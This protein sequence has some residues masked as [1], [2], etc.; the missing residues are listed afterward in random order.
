MKTVTRRELLRYMAFGAAGALLAGCAQPTAT[1]KPEPTAVLEAT[2]A[3]VAEPTAVPPTAAPAKAVKITLVEAWFGV[4]QYRESI[5]PVNAEISKKMQSEGLNVEIQSMIL[6]NHVDKYPVLY[7]SGADFTMAFDA[8]WYKMTSLRDQGALLAI[9]D[10]VRQFGPNIT[11]KVTPEIMDFN[12]MLGHL[13]GIPTGFYYSGTTGVVIREDL[14]LKYGAPAPTSEGGLRS[15]EP[16]LEAIRK[17]EPDLVPFANIPT[18]SI[19]TTNIWRRRAQGGPAKTGLY[20]PDVFED[21]KYLNAED[22]PVYIEACTLLREWWEKGYVPKTDLATSTESENMATMYFV[23]GKC[24]AYQENEPDYKFYDV[25]KQLKKAFPD[26]QAMGYDVTGMR[27]GKV[28]G[29]GQRK[30]WNFIVFNAA[31]PK[32]QQQAG[33]QFFNWLMG[34]QDNLD[35]WWFGIE[36]VNYKKEPD[37]RYSDIGGVDQTR[38][39][40][41]EWYVSGCP[42]RFRRLAIDLPKEAEEAIK[43]Y[44]TADNWVFNPYEAFEVDTKPIEAELAALAAVYNEA[45]HGLDSGQMPVAEAKAMMSKLMDEAGRQTVKAAIQKQFDD[46]RVAHPQ[47]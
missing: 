5:D 7:A 17:N 41:R 27:A 10:P 46:W 11:E 34:S 4:P 9:E 16:F 24:A 22:D 2:Q 12:Y 42:G 3:P 28:K 14:R 38:N 45:A 43:F 35:M 19:T 26:A 40:R 25:G 23:P 6:D 36:G 30:Q 33:I 32:E 18:Y 39:Y 1:P 31:A 44:S 37:N 13:Y 47:S 29:I 21:T 20:V 8:P 15:L